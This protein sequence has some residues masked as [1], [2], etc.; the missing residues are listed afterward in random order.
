MFLV[1]MKLQKRVLDPQL[2]YMN[3]QKVPVFYIFERLSLL[4]YYNQIPSVIFVYQIM[5][6][7]CCVKMFSVY[8][9][10]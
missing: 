2:C 5:L 4:S 8:D 6:F 1:L 9:V 10:T 7:I 3:A